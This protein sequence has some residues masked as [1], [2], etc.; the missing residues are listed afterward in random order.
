MNPLNG[1]RARN[2]AAIERQKEIATAKYG[3]KFRA[4]VEHQISV[5]KWHLRDPEKYKHRLAYQN[6]TRVLSDDNHALIR[7]RDNSVIA[8]RAPLNDNDVLDALNSSI[9]SISRKRS[10]SG[11]HRHYCITIPRTGEPHL[12]QNYGTDGVA[13]N[14][15]V[16]RNERLWD[17]MTSIFCLVLPGV[18]HNA[19]RYPLPNDMDR[20]C[21]AWT[22]CT[23]NIDTGRASQEA[24]TT[25]LLEKNKCAWGVSCLC[26]FGDFTGGAVVF[27]HLR[28]IIEMSQGDLLL[29]P[30]H[31]IDYYFEPSTGS[32]HSVITCVHKNMSSF[33]TTAFGFESPLLKHK[34]KNT[35]SRKKKNRNKNGERRVKIKREVTGRPKPVKV[36]REGTAHPKPV[37]MKKEVA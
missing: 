3:D 7:G 1:Q 22:G 18:H 23:V 14:D 11:I 13:A 25:S 10:S 27:P 29:F 20:L 30:D 36:K 21:G 34:K 17:A 19:R 28:L 9:E 12:S 32:R 15:F 24:S 6:I 4:A 16:T 33:W 26:T 37:K 35:S 31:L 8:Y 2:K 5:T